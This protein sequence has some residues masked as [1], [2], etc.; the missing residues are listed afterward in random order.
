[1]ILSNGVQTMVCFITHI[2]LPF[3]P[4]THFDTTKSMKYKYHTLYLYAIIECFYN[5]VKT[6]IC[7]TIYQN[8]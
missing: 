1:M 6:A 3:A 8:N 4:K 2:W 7:H 5:I